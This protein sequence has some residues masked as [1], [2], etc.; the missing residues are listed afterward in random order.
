LKKRFFSLSGFTNSLFHILWERTAATTPAAR[1]T[2]KM[3]FA[4][5]GPGGGWHWG[6]AGSAAATHGIRAGMT[7]SQKFIQSFSQR[8]LPGNLP[9][10]IKTS[11]IQ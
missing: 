9:D 1:T 11:F 10:M 7:Q 4:V 2:L 3:P 5:S 6:H 8:N